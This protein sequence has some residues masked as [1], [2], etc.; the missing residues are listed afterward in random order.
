MTKR[1]QSNFT[2][3][4]VITGPEDI[5]TEITADCIKERPRRSS[6]KT[7]TKRLMP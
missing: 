4:L 3:S 1:L 2:K 7:L 5:T 6:L